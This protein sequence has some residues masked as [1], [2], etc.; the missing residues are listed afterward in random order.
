MAEVFEVEGAEGNA[1]AEGGRGDKGINKADVVRKMQAAKIS[2]GLKRFRV[3]GPDQRKRR[4]QP[5][6]NNC[7]PRILSVLIKLHQDMARQGQ[8]SI[9][10][11]RIPG[12][13]GWK[14]PLKVN[15]YVCIKQPYSGGHIQWP[16]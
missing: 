11:G 12:E 4:R 7:L 16:R 9:R 8:H 15:H 2:D 10:H 13:G 5:V 1:E 3:R 14:S 6:N